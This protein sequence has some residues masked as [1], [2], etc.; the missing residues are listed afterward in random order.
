MSKI[1][2]PED[3]LSDM[4]DLLSNVHTTLG[5]RKQVSAQNPVCILS[6]TIFVAVKRLAYIKDKLMQL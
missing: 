5:E 1:T 2:H 3:L 6:L 4:N